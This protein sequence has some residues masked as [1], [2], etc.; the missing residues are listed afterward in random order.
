MIPGNKGN[1]MEPPLIK[2][3]LYNHSMKLIVS[4]MIKEP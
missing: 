1:E 2:G 3:Q 4:G